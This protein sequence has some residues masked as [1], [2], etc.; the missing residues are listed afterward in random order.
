MVKVLQKG[1]KIL[2][3]IAEEVP[4][5]D[6]LSAKIQN[7]ILQMRDILDNTGDAVALS[8]PQIGKSLRIFVVSKKIFGGSDFNDIENFHDL[9]FINPKITKTSKEKQWL[10]EG[11][12]SIRGV[13]GEVQ[14]CKK[15]TVQAL[16]EHG[17]IFSF[18]AGELL[19]QVFQHEIDHLNGILFDSKAK[20]LREETIRQ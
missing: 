1:E 15:A 5:R 20:N 8:A 14:R 7:I 13:Y 19:A 16:D 12:L 9:I 18:G 3:E 6:I 11:C 10:E 2:E 17:K 4:L